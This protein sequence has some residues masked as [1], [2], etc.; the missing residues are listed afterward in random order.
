[1]NAAN[2]RSEADEDAASVTLPWQVSIG[3]LSDRYPELDAE[4][5]WSEENY[6]PYSG[7]FYTGVSEAM[8]AQLDFFHDPAWNQWLRE[9]VGV[10]Q[11]WFLFVEDRDKVKHLHR[12]AG[13]DGLESTTCYAP[14]ALFLA[15]DT[16]RD[17]VRD[18]LRGLY[19]YCATKRGW[20][21]PPPLPGYIDV[22]AGDEPPLDWLPA[23]GAEGGA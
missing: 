17:V 7:L 23:A 6:N 10:D 2:H 9:N 18:L 1:M 16:E 21:E 14:V 8:L 20:P 3:W 4:Q 13:A 22:P 12:R 19:A 5:M 15:D 11:E